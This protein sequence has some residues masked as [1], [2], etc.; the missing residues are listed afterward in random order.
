MGCEP[1]P[2]IDTLY[3]RDE[4]FKVDVTRIRRPEFSIPREWVVTEKVDGCNMRVSLEE[5]LRSGLDPDYPGSLTDVIVWVMRFY[6]HK[7]NS[8]I[9]D[10]LLEHLQK[11]FTLEKM[12]YLW[13]GKNNCARCDGTGREDSG[14]PKVLSELASPFPY[15]CDCVEPYP[16]TLYGEGYGARIQKGGGDYRKGGDVSFRL[17]D[18]LIGETW[19]RRVDVEDVAG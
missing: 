19:L 12:R 6:G 8:Q 13:R 14:Q 9:P 15:A 7:E 17:F 3:E 5:G 10:F 18:V 16:I 11:T 4:N 2:K 1:Y